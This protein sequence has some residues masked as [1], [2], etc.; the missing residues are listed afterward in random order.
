[1][2]DHALGEVHPEHSP[3]GA[4]PAE[5]PLDTLGGGRT[6]WAIARVVSPVPHPKSRSLSP[7]PSEPCFAVKSFAAAVLIK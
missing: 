1:M 5:D 7:A 4:Q 6:T 3:R 2:V